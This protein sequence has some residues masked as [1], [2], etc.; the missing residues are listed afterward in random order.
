MKKILS[1][2]V[3]FALT[4]SLTVPA[5]AVNYEFS[6]G[7]D[8]LPGFGKTTTYSQTVLPDPETENLRRS[9]DA[10]LMPPPFGF[11]GGDIPTEPSSP[12][13]NNL[14]ESTGYIDDALY[15]SELPNPSN[16]T[17]SNPGYYYPG[18]QQITAPSYFENGSMG[19]LYVPSAKKTINVYEGES[20]SNLKKGIG[21]FTNTSAWD[22]NVGIAGHN[23]GTAAYFSF[24]KDLKIGDL[25]TYTTPYGTRTYEIYSKTTVK[26]TDFSSLG[27]SSVNILTLITCVE[28]I[29]ELRWCVQAREI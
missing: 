6:T 18:Y 17:V 2:A 12:Y 28:N 25:L 20:L 15:Y 29:P 9:K 24:V 23:R 3:A 5:F 14:R 16:V 27:Y 8:T 4:A 19:V 22:G 1:T 21:H 11:Y 7:D 10:A 26:E 13:H